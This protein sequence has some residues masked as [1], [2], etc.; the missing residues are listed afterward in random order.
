MCISNVQNFRTFYNHATDHTLASLELCRAWTVGLCKW[1][2]Q[3]LLD[4]RVLYAQV[5]RARSLFMDQALP[6]NTLDTTAAGWQPPGANAERKEG[7][8][9][10]AGNLALM[11]KY[12][13]LHD[14]CYNTTDNNTPCFG[15][16]LCRD[17]LAKAVRAKQF[18]S[19]RRPWANVRVPCRG[20][21]CTSWG[22]PFEQCSTCN[23][24]YQP[25]G[26]H[27]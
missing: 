2:S 25:P 10:T 9:A 22:T 1:P 16:D 11:A 27:N 4:A 26:N 3:I 8:Q 18:A 15:S 17:C 5:F 20:D 19:L 23:D 21:Q 14:L 6:Y 12:E 13:S 7:Q 24:Y